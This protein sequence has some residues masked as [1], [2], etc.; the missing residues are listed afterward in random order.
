MSL[1]S[2]LNDELIGL[3]N[4]FGIPNSNSKVITRAYNQ[5]NLKDDQRKHL[6]AVSSHIARDLLQLLGED[7]Q[8]GSGQNVAWEAGI[9][10]RNQLRAGLRTKIRLYCGVEEE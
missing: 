8:H 6:P 4:P 5:N 7:E 9:D 3:N 1:H 2:R 10:W